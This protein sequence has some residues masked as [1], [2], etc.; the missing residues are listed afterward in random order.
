MSIVS[1]KK[2]TLIELLVVIAIIAILASMLLPG[3][4]RAK[5]RASV[6]SCL[7][8]LKQIG[9]GF[10]LYRDDFGGYFPDPRSMGDDKPNNKNAALTYRRNLGVDGETLG[11]AAA[12]SP[13]LGY[14][15]SVWYCSGMHPMLRKYKSSYYIS[16]TV[17]VRL[18]TKYGG[19]SALSN[20]K[21]EGKTYY[22]MPYGLEVIA[23]NN[24]NLWPAEVNVRG[25][26]SS[27]RNSAGVKLQRFYPH[28]A[29]NPDDS[30]TYLLADG[31]AMQKAK[32]VALKKSYKKK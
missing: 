10:H 14:G 30:N 7:N 16:V 29:S 8:N 24:N 28:G 9:Y 18:N 4:Q 21:P 27:S 1:N 12:L 26:R 15:S 11:A 6:A 32:H 23:M 13:Y 25:A 3:L 20:K 22:E 2:F 5:A 19:P 17:L 31:S